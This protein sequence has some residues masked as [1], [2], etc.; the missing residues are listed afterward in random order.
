[1][2]IDR[3][4]GTPLVLIPG[5]QGRWEWMAPAVNALASRVRVLTGS[6][7][8]DTGATHTIDPALGFDSHTAWLDALLDRAGVARA[9]LCG[10]SFGGWIA[11][12]YAAARPERVTSLTLA[13]TPAPDWRP[14]CRVEW[15]L[16]APR[17]LS[18]VF[19]LTSPVRLYP[20]VA[21]AFPHVVDRARFAAGHLYRVTRH[22][23]SPVRMA[24][25]MRLAA[26]VDFL[27]DCRRVR[28]PVQVITG[29]A[30]LDRVVAVES[31]RAYLDAIPE[32]RYHEIERTGHI[33]LVTRPE[34][35]AGVVAAFARDAAAPAAAVP[36]AA[37]A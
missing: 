14:G 9:A 26:T 21:I 20:E 30:G 15:Y 16:R 13:S 31:T 35:F 25:R 32:A 5:I 33:G 27:A 6:L 3:G 10:V 28:A 17:L 19:A 18:P 24:Q 1:M 23:M 7:P 12:H 4:A 34:R 22:A 37:H 36:A 2:I 11:L 29:A 8:G